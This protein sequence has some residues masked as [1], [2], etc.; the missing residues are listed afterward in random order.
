MPIELV[1]AS[2]PWSISIGMPCVPSRFMLKPQQNRPKKIF[3]NGAVRMASRSLNVWAC[4]P[5]RAR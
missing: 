1:K 2:K 5:R 3:Q 4:A